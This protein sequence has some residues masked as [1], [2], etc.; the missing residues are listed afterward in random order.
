[1][2]LEKKLL[3]IKTKVLKFEKNAILKV[4]YDGN[5]YISNGS[6][7]LTEGYFIPKCRDVFQT[8][9]NA[10]VALQVTQNF[11]RTHPLRRDDEDFLKKHDRINDRKKRR[12][13]KEEADDTNCIF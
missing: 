2:Y 12:R 11:N 5:F 4:D 6:H 1:M 3:K 10:L 13:I 8:W 7:D 9:S